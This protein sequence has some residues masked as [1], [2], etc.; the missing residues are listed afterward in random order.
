VTARS[1]RT[2]VGKSA[3]PLTH[4]RSQQRFQFRSPIVQFG[5]T[6]IRDFALIVAAALLSVPVR[7]ESRVSAIP[8]SRLRSVWQMA[9]LAR[10]GAGKAA[11]RSA[12]RVR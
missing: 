7:P 10:R 6:R 9:Y 11:V 3:T 5:N 12:T 8:S 1:H 4:G 2:I